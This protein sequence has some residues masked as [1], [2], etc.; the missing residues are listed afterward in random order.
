MLL[1]YQLNDDT[2]LYS[3]SYVAVDLS[4]IA[5]IR[6]SGNFLWNEIHQKFEVRECL[7]SFGAESFVFQFAIQKCKD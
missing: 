5:R 3:D 7:V 1:P 6:V 4:S 2:Q